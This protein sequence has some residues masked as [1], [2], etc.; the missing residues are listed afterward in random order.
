[1]NLTSVRSPTSHDI[2]SLH[3]GSESTLSPNNMPR[4]TRPSA[5][6]VWLREYAGLPENAERTR[7]R[8][9]EIE[10]VD[11][12]EEWTNRA[13]LIV[14]KRPLLTLRD[15]R[16]Q[17]LTALVGEQVAETTPFSVRLFHRGQ[18]ASGGAFRRSDHLHYQVVLPSHDSASLCVDMKDETH[19]LSIA[20]LAEIK[21]RIE[22]G[23]SVHDL[24]ELIS[25][26]LNQAGTNEH[27]DPSQI[28]L[29]AIGGLRPGSI[30]GRNWY[31][32]M[33]ASAWFC[34]KLCVR[35]RPPNQQIIIQALNQE[36]IFSR[37]KLNPQG[38]TSARSIRNWFL[39]RVVLTIKGSNSWNW[40]ANREDITCHERDGGTQLHDQSRIAG[41]A[42]VTIALT[43]DVAARYIEAEAS[44]VPDTRI[45]VVCGDNKRPS[46]IP[47]RITAACEHANEM[48]KNCV[49]QWIASSLE[50]TWDR[51][52]CPQCPRRL[53]FID[54]AALADRATFAR[55]DCHK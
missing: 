53:Q 4:S 41:G 33:V 11:L 27:L 5:I 47:T 16:H 18:I 31:V 10:L 36:Y 8:R 34:Q 50:G 39:R 6:T 7:P 9:Y 35:V 45:C 1:M 26:E 38:T 3:R 30:P 12:D 48:C 29:R 15:V 21:R 25:A 43:R 19:E 23:I 14:D 55:Y 44:M 28:E 22:T 46:D 13:P 20:Q 24:Q 51:M 40:E 32:S 52:R 2:T 17:I 42:T 37:P 54:V 49:E